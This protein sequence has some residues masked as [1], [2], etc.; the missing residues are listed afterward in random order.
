MWT[1]PGGGF[2]RNM[3]VIRSR[4]GRWVQKWM[5][6]DRLEN[7][8]VKWVPPALRGV[9]MD[10]K[11]REEA[12]RILKRMNEVWAMPSENAIRPEILLGANCQKEDAE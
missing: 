1:N 11:H 3:M 2:D 10:I 12:E 5:R 4:S 8:R 6:A 9:V 7:W